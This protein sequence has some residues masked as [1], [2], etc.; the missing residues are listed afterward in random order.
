MLLFRQYCNRGSNVRRDFS[1][2]SVYHDIFAP[3]F[4]RL[5]IIVK[6]VFDSG[7]GKYFFQQ[8]SGAMLAITS[9]G[10]C[11]NSCS[12][13]CALLVQTIPHLSALSLATW[14]KGILPTSKAPESTNSLQCTSWAWKRN[15]TPFTAMPS[16]EVCRK[17][18]L[19]MVVIDGR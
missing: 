7:K 18:L 4:S 10:H 12:S 15:F 8:M 1:L 6:I 9:G 19:E 3:L 16:R 5:I 14:T 2:F 17:H 11:L 13:T